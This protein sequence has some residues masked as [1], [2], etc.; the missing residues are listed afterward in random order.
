MGSDTCDAIVQESGDERI[1]AGA[2]PERVAEGEAQVRFRE[3][4]EPDRD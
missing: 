4:A 3:A 1:E 2:E